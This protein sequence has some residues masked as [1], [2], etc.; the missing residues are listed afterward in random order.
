[1]FKEDMARSIGSVL[2]S[3]GYKRSILTKDYIMYIKRYS[4]ELAFYIKCLDNRERNQ[5]ISIEMIFTTIGTPDD[6]LF[7]SG[8]GIHM[9]ILTVLGD[10]AD[11]IMIRAGEKIVELEGSLSGFAD[12]V[13]N[14]LD[15]AYFQTKRLPIYKRGIL[16]YKIIKEDEQMR[17][18]LHLLKEEVCKLIRN[19][20]ERQAY[21]QIDD[22]VEELPDDYFEDKELGRITDMDI[23]EFTEYI[24]A[25]CVLDA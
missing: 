22:F 11:D 7:V 14:E 1:M 5:E 15:N 13:L 19:Q 21:Q 6:G 3:K 4:E 25:Q 20:E 16:I 8:V 17:Q 2:V 24:Y 9:K 10:A 12:F 23:S 18:K